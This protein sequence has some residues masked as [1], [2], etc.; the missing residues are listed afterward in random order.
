MGSTNTTDRALPQPKHKQNSGLNLRESN[1]RLKMPPA[2]PFSYHFSVNF[3]TCRAGRAR[4]SQSC[5]G[6]HRRTSSPAPPRPAQLRESAH[7][8]LRAA[9]GRLR[10]RA[11][12]R[13][14]A[15]ARRRAGAAG[16][17]R[18]RA[19][20]CAAVPLSVPAV[21]SGSGSG[22]AAVPSPSSL[23]PRS[24]RSRPWPGITTTSSS[25]SSSATA[26]RARGPPLPGR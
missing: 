3:L 21:C 7:A 19:D 18:R 14:V 23:P 2:L 6:C 11:G 15:R 5:H 4:P 12:R 8:Q 24:R 9:L 22:P 25:C 16:G 20:A 10:A 13:G 1:R 17:L 26:V